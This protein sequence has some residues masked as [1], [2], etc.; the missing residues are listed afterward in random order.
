M[1]QKEPGE[2]QTPK[3]PKGPKGFKAPKGVKKQM[4][5]SILFFLGGLNTVF[6]V[7]AGLPLDAFHVILMLGG[8]LLFLY[9]AIQKMGDTPDEPTSDEE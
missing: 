6:S 2:P 9:G 1:T 4:F 5:G 7:K 3:G 8:G